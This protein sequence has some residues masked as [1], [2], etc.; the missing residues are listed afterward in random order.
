MKI[1]L[2]I[3]LT[4]IIITLLVCSTFMAIETSKYRIRVQAA[5]ELLRPSIQV[6]PEPKPN[7]H[8]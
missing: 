5:Q 2:T 6:V 8:L 4:A 3:C 1:A 7:D